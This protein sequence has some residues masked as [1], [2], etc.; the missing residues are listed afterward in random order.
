MIGIW[1]GIG[2]S[3]TDK[4]RHVNQNEEVEP[5]NFA[6]PE[7]NGDC[8]I[9]QKVRN[10]W[11]RYQILLP[12]KWHSILLFSS[13]SLHWSQRAFLSLLAILWNSTFK[14][15]YLSFSPLPFTSL[16]FS[17]ICKA[18][19]DNNFAFLHSFFLQMVLIIVSC[20]M[21]WTS[22]HSSS[23]TLSDLIPWICLSLPQYNCK[24]FGLGHTQMV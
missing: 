13:I 8:F 16:L 14:W 18:S 6:D 20:A 19:S 1:E 21:S 22:V 2:C 23:G 11:R 9:K 17:A 4:A 3:D 10:T 7:K 15:S 5:E 24:E 12:D